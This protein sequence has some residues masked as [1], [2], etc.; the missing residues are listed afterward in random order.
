VHQK[1]ADMS[2]WTSGGAS[3]PR[4]EVA[5]RQVYD[6]SLPFNR[7]MPTYYFYRQVQDAPFFSIVSHP[8]ITP[9][10]D[11]YV[12]HVSFVTHT[13]THV[14][15]PRHFRTDGLTIDQIEPD[16]WL[17]EGPVIGVPKGPGEVVT[18]ADLERSGLDVRVGDLVAINTGWHH[19]YC[20]PAT[21][22]IAARAYMEEAPGLCEESA[23]WLVERGVKTVLV[24]T[25]ALDACIHMPY[26]DSSLETHRVL[27]AENIPGVEGLGGDLDLVTG[28]RCLISCAPVR[29]EGGEAFPLRALA[30]PLS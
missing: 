3:G 29:Y 13:G 7:N 14:D 22:P 27:F 19:R 28:K 12:T 25:P 9:V 6:L 20:G 17:G 26:G 2:T 30:I 15:A 21:D 10:E 11:G 16:R 8:S 5:A 1:E 23:R 4:A 18:A 24:D